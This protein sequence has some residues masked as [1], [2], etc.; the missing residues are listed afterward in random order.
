MLSNSFCTSDSS[1]TIC[2]GGEVSSFIVKDA[3]IFSKIADALLI[4]SVG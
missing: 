2:A 3:K 4:A 1:I